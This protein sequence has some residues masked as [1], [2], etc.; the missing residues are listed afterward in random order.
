MRSEVRK[1]SD[2]RKRYYLR[3]KNNKNN[4]PKIKYLESV[5]H[6]I[7]YTY[8]RCAFRNDATRETGGGRL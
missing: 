4:S 1:T 3:K 2:T 5:F 8:E 6:H 7:Y